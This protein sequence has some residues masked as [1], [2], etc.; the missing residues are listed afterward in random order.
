MLLDAEISHPG[1]LAAASSVEFAFNLRTRGYDPA[2][3]KSFLS[4]LRDGGFVDIKRAW[5]YLPMGMEPSEPQIPREAPAPRV[6]SQIEEY[7]AVQGPV[8]STGDIASITGVLGGW[9][10]EQWLVQ[11]RM[12]MGRDR[13]KLLEG[14]GAM[15]DEGRKNGAGWTC[16]SGWAMKPKRRRVSHH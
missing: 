9:M 8:G 13:P 10:W 16:L 6:L 4:R 7:E 14:I 2:A 3:S 15:F 12:E 11:L 1:P 5:M